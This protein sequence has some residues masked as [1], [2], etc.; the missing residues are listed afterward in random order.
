MK[1]VI[2]FVGSA[3]LALAVLLAPQAEAQSFRTLTEK[4]T[5]DSHRVT[6]A[7][8]RA[9]NV[10]VARKS[11]REA[12]PSLRQAMRVTGLRKAP[13]GLRAAAGAEFPELR[14]SVTYSYNDDTSLGLYSIAEDASISLLERG[15]IARA[16]GAAL[17]GVYYCIDVFTLFGMD[18]V[19]VYLYDVETGEEINHFS[20]DEDN[21]YLDMAG[22]PTSGIIY[23]LGINEAGTSVQLLKVA[24]TETSITNTVVG[25]LPGYWSGLA[26]DAQ[27]QLY[28]LDQ[29][30]GN[31]LAEPGNLYKLNKLT[32]EPTLVGSTGMYPYYSGSATID[33]RSGRMFWIVS[34]LAPAG[35]EEDSHLCEVNLA[36]GAA[37]LLGTF[38]GQ[39]QVQGLFVK[40]PL[41]EPGAP[42]SATDLT[43]TFTPGSFSGTL[44]F[45]APATTFDG[46]D[47]SGALSYEVGIEGMT[48]RSGSAQWGETLT[49]PV[50]L[51]ASGEYTFSVVMKNAAGAGPA[52]KT[53]TYVG[54]GVPATTVATLSYFNGQ[55]QLSWTP[56]AT[57]VGGTGHI[58]PA[59][60]TYTVTRFP[61]DV[62]V[63]E[64]P[65]TTFSETVEEPATLTQYYYT[66]VAHCGDM[67]SAAATS[68]AVALGS[69]R[70]PYSNTFDNAASLEGYTIIDGNGDG[71]VWDVDGG[72]ARMKY[73]SYVDMDDWMITPGIRMEAGKSYKVT[74]EA[75][76]NL[77]D[78][79]VE[80]K[81]G[82][83]PTVA[84]MTETLVPPTLLE[85]E[86]YAYKSLEMG[87]YVTPAITGTYYIGIHGMSDADRY[88]LYIDNLTIAAAV[89]GAAPGLVT[90]F[91]ALTDP[92]GAF[93]ATVSFKAPAVTQDGDPL[94]SITAIEVKRGSETVKTFT[95]VQP[96]QECSFVD[97]VGESGTVTYTAVA[98]NEEGDGSPATTSTFV[99]IDVP[100][101]PE[102]LKITES[103]T[104]LGVVTVSWDA[105]G[106][107]RNGQPINPALVTYSIAAYDDDE[108]NWV[109][110]K[111][112]LTE[113]SYTF[114]AVEEGDQQFVQYAVYS[115]TTGGVNGDATDM[116][117]VGTPYPGMDESFTD[118][119]SDYIWGVAYTAGN[120]RWTIYNES[121]INGVTSF[122]ADGGYAGM[123]CYVENGTSSL[124]SGKISLEG[125]TNPG[126]TFFTFG[127]VAQDNNTIE[128]YA[129]EAG[130]AEWHKESTIVVA[131]VA[132]KDEWGLVT[133][134]LDQYAGKVVELRIAATTVSSYYTFIDR[135]HAGSL[136]DFDL[137]AGAITAPEYVN[138]GA[139]YKA[140]VKVTNEGI[141]AVESYNKHN[142]A[143]EK[144]HDEV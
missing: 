47:G 119:H 112:G 55:M 60:V 62:V 12:T 9:L 143:Q 57:T 120:A 69:I 48:I 64:G 75:S 138:A 110:F 124:I 22:D 25:D 78:E 128:I 102:N 38:P 50:T 8:P 107:D 21:I 139:A 13:Q 122:D 137:A 82:M 16:G 142:L 104:E 99:G 53:T 68:N 43:A 24:I 49:V 80:A 117:A 58:D 56:V 29:Y 136:L 74:F 84:G 79:R 123:Q 51:A 113:T 35:Q 88:W 18:I 7:A 96:G 140:S 89:S 130:D 109:V 65:A 3:L 72:H 46:E 17:N 20:G 28:A 141:K 83:Q 106:A 111:S 52:A 129:R 67:N 4:S 127:D 71:T 87:D 77:Y 27:G 39:E 36:T 121:S 132:A 94:T 14:G 30:S 118:G 41:A 32:A 59:A 11:R 131:D 33:T 15:V 61:D 37:T 70:P 90:D 97:E 91:K 66:V 76:T 134:P 116:A 125:C 54:M 5:E 34:P 93:K 2:S 92:D 86:T 95:A 45:T 100:A 98:S 6:P 26:C 101:A 23:A 126:F 85:G 135:L 105:V 114:R 115:E 19:T 1:K 63:Y 81:W 44:Q 40:L 10:P 31:D 73:N 144:R 133:I 103:A 42:A 108:S